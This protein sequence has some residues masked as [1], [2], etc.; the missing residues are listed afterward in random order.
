MSYPIRYSAAGTKIVETDPAG[1]LV[2]Y[3]DYEI[4]KAENERLRKLFADTERLMLLDGEYEAAKVGTYARL[5][6]EVE[7][8]RNLG[9]KLDGYVDLVRHE[10]ERLRKA[11]DAMVPLLGRG[12]YH[13]ARINWNAAKEDRQP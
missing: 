6:A 1:P 12:D 5:K 13:D 11:G 3:I 9:I 7:R 2:E 4:L 10:N 8:L